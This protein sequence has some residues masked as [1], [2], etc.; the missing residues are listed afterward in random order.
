MAGAG[1]GL[2]TAVA[3]VAAPVVAE[4]L[5]LSRTGR[6]LISH[7]WW[8][9][10]QDARMRPVAAAIWATLTYHLWVPRRRWVEAGAVGAL[11]GA[12]VGV[13]AHALDRIVS[14]THKP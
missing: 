13:T 3:L 5:V 10:V 11:A 8:P 6:P 1:R 12:V 4:E 9:C 7:H 14:Q 2:V